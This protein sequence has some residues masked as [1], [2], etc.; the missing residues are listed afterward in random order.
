MEAVI[1][2][3][4]SALTVSDLERSI[5]F[6]ARFGFEVERRVTNAG[7]DAARVTQVPQAHLS[8]ALLT[9]GRLRAELTEY[10]PR[11]RPEP[12][13]NNDLGSAHICI[14]VRDLEAIYQR[15]QTEGIT[16]TSHPQ[17]HPGGASL[18]Y[19]KDPD[20]LTVELLEVRD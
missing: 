19:F 4:H 16:F 6:Y 17:H 1:G 9:L 13:R 8:I 10:K 20:G 5:G 18:A 15:L 12:P 3:H 2:V 11:V 14:Q 7:P